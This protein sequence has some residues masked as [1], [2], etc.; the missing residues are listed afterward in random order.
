MNVEVKLCEIADVTKLAGFEFTKYIS[1]EETGEIIALRALNLRNGVLDLTDVKRINRTVSDML[2]RS[3]LF[4]NDIL[5]TYTG[6]GY[7]DCAII[8]ENDKYHLAPNICKITPKTEKVIPYYLYSYIRSASFYKQMTNHMVGS[9]QPTI[10][11]KILRELKIPLPSISIQRKIAAILSALD[12]KIAI[13]RAI[14]DNLE[15]QAK[16]YFKSLFIDFAAYN[17]EF[18]DSPIGL[19]PATMEID[20]I[21]NIPHTLETGKRPKG[22][23]V[24]KG[25]P[26]IGAENVKQLGVVDFSSAK[27][28]PEEFAF[29]MK[30]GR[31][32]GYEVL[33]YK[34]GGKP[35]TFIPHF[36][37]FGEGFPY[38][39]CFINEHVF[40]LDFGHRGY[41]EFCYL[42]L[43]TDYPFHW[44]ANN[45]G[46][47]A[48][49][50]INQ[51]DVND[52]WIPT[53][54]NESVKKF[55]EWVQPIFTTILSNCS[56][57]VKLANI[58]DSLLSRL[59]SGEIDVSEIEF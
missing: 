40:K 59:L 15:Q 37:M 42:Y 4:Q 24:E 47:A 18:V 57:N 8:T 6:N 19:I 51:Q 23:A 20:Q 9:S 13:N 53:I 14:N 35:G 46:K 22:G 25:V 1:Y 58:R 28:I 16:E 36:S 10:P 12:E 17:G 30:R 31:I 49:P 11:M 32:Y 33:L 29:S 3:K 50:G 48:V 2:P 41:N 5:L 26:S 45:G 39:T 55:C 7:G 52:I 44:L 54:H 27:F 38:E 56:E 21:S 43:Q 34:D